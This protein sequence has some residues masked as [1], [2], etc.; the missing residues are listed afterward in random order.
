[1][2][3]TCP[4]EATP[5]VLEQQPHAWE[6]AEPVAEAVLRGEGGVAEG[7]E[8]GVHPAAL[9]PREHHQQVARVRGELVQAGVHSGREALAEVLD[10]VGGEA[11]LDRDERPAYR[12]ALGQV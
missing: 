3:R 11:V 4:A 2:S 12:K 10:E 8:G 9:L 5:L 6:R 1:M 7:R